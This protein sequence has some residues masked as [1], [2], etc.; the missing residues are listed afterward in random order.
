LV[1]GNRLVQLCCGGCKAKVLKDPLAAFA[2]IDAAK[3]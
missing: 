2:L 1:V 3:K